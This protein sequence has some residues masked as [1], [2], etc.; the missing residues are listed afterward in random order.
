MP[1]A[2]TD[3]DVVSGRVK[4]DHSDATN[5]AIDELFRL[6]HDP[7]VDFTLL[8]SPWT[9]REGAN[10][11]DAGRRAQHEEVYGELVPI[12][13]RPDTLMQLRPLRAGSGFVGPVPVATDSVF[14]RIREILGP[15]N[16]VDARHLQHAIR[17][18]V[19]YF[20]TLDRDVIGTRAEIVAEFPGVSIVTPV[21]LVEKL[22]G[23]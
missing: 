3:N 9:A 13:E 14:L 21:E 6:H 22:L 19:D 4:S 7:N 8:T 12:P 18:E 2:Y 20:V 5:A 1:T 16:E 11:G 15:K 17:A 10:W 23:T